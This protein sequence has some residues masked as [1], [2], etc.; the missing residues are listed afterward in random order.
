M[1][2]ITEIIEPKQKYRRGIWGGV[3][4]PPLYLD[5]Y[6]YHSSNITFLDLILED[7]RQLPCLIESEKPNGEK[8]FWEVDCTQRKAKAANKRKL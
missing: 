1:Y 6:L 2:T 8:H 4:N 5:D 3:R 7:S